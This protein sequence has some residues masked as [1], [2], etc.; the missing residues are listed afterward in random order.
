VLCCAVSCDVVCCVI[1]YSF[2]RWRLL[3]CIVVVCGVRCAVMKRT[4]DDVRTHVH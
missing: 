2:W 1:Y 4:Q 3:C